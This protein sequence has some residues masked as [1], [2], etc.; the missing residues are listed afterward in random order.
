MGIKGHYIDGKTFYDFKENF[1]TLIAVL[2]HNMT[3]MRVDVRWIKRIVFF[4]AGLMGTIA[5]TAFSF[6]ATHN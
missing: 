4:F 6:W 2:N 3:E 1:D 5:V